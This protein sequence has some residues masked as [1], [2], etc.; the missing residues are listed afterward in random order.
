MHCCLVLQRAVVLCCVRKIDPSLCHP[1][2]FAHDNTG[3]AAS[4]LGAQRVLLTDLAYSL[5]L[6]AQNAAHNRH[7]LGGAAIPCELDWCAV[8]ELQSL[9]DPHPLALAA[10]PASATLSASAGGDETGGETGGETCELG[11]ID[12]VLIADC[13]W[14][15]DLVASLVKTIALLLAA[16]NAGTGEKTGEQRQAA[17]LRQRES[18]GGDSGGG[19]GNSSDSGDSDDSHGRGGGHRGFAEDAALLELAEGMGIGQG[20]EG[21]LV[22]PPAGGPLG[23]TSTAAR[24][25]SPSGS[26]GKG[27]RGCGRRA[28]VGLISY[29][30]RFPAVHRAFWAALRGVCHVEEVPRADIPWVGGPCAE[31][32]PVQIFKQRLRGEGEGDGEGV[33]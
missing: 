26:A 18:G 2:R 6:A 27:A 13:V 23:S 7:L 28:A 16:G 17:A 33:H 31:M 14:R 12:V 8:A 24:P 19:G 5:P 25:S 15:A 10:P 30:F 11:D 20:D 9:G 4:V 21:I 29:T 22:V 32:A 3:I 1:I